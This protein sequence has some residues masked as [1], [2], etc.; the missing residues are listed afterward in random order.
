MTEARRPDG[1]GGALSRDERIDD[2]QFYTDPGAELIIDDIVLY[3]AADPEET[4]PFPRRPIFTGWFDTGRRGREW[5]G[6]FELVEH[7]SPRTWK[8]ARSVENPRLRLPWI[9]VHLRGERLLGEKVRLRFR[10]RLDGAD[11]MRVTL[12]SRAEDQK[13]SIPVK[14]LEQGRWASKSLDI[15]GAPKSAEEIEFVLP[16]GAELLLDDLLIC[17]P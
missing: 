15:D 9:R 2:I 7:E 14:Y 17:E 11:S 12:A 16:R 13:V 3:D 1:S 10:Y 4:E 5:P 8:A 6:D